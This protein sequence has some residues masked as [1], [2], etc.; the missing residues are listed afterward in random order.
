MAK[1][2]WTR[3]A[4]STDDLTGVLLRVMRK[5]GVSIGLVLCSVVFLD[6][7]AGASTMYPNYPLGHGHSCRANYHK[8]LRHRLV[9]GRHVP[10]IECVWKR[11]APPPVPTSTSIGVEVGNASP[12]GAAFD[13]TA[14]PDVTGDGFINPGK[15][16]LTITMLDSVNGETVGIWTNVGAFSTASTQPGI[17][18]SV[19]A[20]PS[21]DA[22]SVETADSSYLKGPAA[23][24]VP[25]R[26]LLDG[27][28]G[29]Q[30][31]FKGVTGYLPSM[32]PIAPVQL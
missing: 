29:V 1:S 24:T 13:I 22:L 20:G 19:S 18:W 9:S 25:S 28:I 30:A 4:P 6:A 23:V 5:R 12:R 3:A 2:T 21:T 7:S 14:T 15:G 27:S 10:Y 32:S 8:R 17:F 26:D 16:N 31:T 11:P